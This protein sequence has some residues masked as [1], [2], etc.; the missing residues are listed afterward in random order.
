[1]HGALLVQHGNNFTLFRKLSAGSCEYGSPTDTSELMKG[2]GLSSLAEQLGV[3]FV[4]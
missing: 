2:T 3:S 4:N 1:M